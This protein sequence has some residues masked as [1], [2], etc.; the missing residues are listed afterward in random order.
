M[1]KFLNGSHTATILSVFARAPEGACFAPKE[2]WALTGIQDTTGSPY[3]RKTLMKAGVIR[4]DDCGKYFLAPGVTLTELADGVEVEGAVAVADGDR[5][6]SPRPPRKD[7]A[8]ALLNALR[9]AL[10][11]EGIECA[12]QLAALQEAVTAA[13]TKKAEAAKRAAKVAEVERLKAAM[14]KLQAELE[15]AS[16][17]E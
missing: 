5:V 4:Q 17:E 7:K 3:L 11:A 1:T 12:E 16:T 15:A 8:E 10:A 9:A 2:I 6:V 14:A 13:K